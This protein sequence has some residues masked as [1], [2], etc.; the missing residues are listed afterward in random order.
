MSLG[1][2]KR[3]RHGQEGNPQRV[4]ALARHH[5]DAR[6]LG[7]AE[8]ADRRATPSTTF[9][10]TT[11]AA[12]SITAS[13]SSRCARAPRSSGRA[14]ARPSATSPGR[15]FI[16]C[17]GGYG[18]Y[19]AGIR[20]PEGRQGR[21][22]PARADAALDRRSCSTR[23][24]ARS[25]SCSARSRRATSST[26]SSSTT[27]PTRSRARSS[28]RAS[29][30]ARRTSSRRCADSTARAAARCRC[31]ASGSTASRSCRSCPASSS[32]SS[33]T[34][35]RSSDELYKA[36]ADGR[37]RRRGHHG[38]DPGRGGRDRAAGRLLAAHPQGVRRVRRAADRRR[39]PDRARAHRQDVRRRAL[40]HRARHH[41]P[42][43]GA[44]RRRHAALGLHLDAQDLEGAREQSL[45][46]HVDLRRQPARLRRGDRRGQ[47]DARGGPRRA[48]RRARAS[49]SSGSSSRCSSLTTGSSARRAARA[50]SSGSSSRTRRSATRSSRASSTA[51][52][53]SPARSR[54]RRSCASS[55]R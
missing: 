30:R 40:G 19:S 4:A 18:I 13:R 45:H 8:A 9:R 14:R 25:R 29:T 26:R 21:R 5:L 10:S 42:R 11:T 47:R 46:P 43:Q 33:A 50:C 53:S 54:T 35:T 32:S 27:A 2:R 28:S 36:D 7:R 6:A 31:S 48:R 37:G 41:V 1:N 38:A 17:L 15:E 34:P 44:R 39:G 49:T 12:T 23:C 55:R 3:G 51:A 20:H 24:A 16:D 52:S 22:R